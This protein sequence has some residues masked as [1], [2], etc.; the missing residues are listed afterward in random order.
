MRKGNGEC[1]LAT[2]Y[3]SMHLLERMGMVK[4]FDFGDGAGASNWWA[5]TMTATITISSA[6]D[7]R[8]SLKSR[9]VSRGKLKRKLPPKTVSKASPTNW[10]FW[11]LPGMSVT[12]PD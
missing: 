2:I 12:I 7:A 4:R 9:N 3:R 6:L 11:N 8:K 1:N 5:K 10:S